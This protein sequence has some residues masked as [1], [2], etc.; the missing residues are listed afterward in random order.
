[1]CRW[2][3]SRSVA[4]IEAP[5][6][7]RV[8]AIREHLMEPLRR[9]LLNEGLWESKAAGSNPVAPEKQFDQIN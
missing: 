9:W 3:E 6:K 5:A 4:V 8:G 1:M 7:A 2:V